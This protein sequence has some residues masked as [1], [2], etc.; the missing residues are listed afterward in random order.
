MW[1]PCRRFN[2]HWQLML[3]A[4]FSHCF[5][6]FTGCFTGFWILLNWC[7]PAITCAF[8]I[9]C[10]SKTCAA[11]VW[12]RK[13][14][15]RSFYVWKTYQSVLTADFSSL[16]CHTPVARKRKVLS[17]LQ[18]NCPPKVSLREGE[19]SEKE[20]SV[21]SFFLILFH[22]KAVSS[23]WKQLCSCWLPSLCI[24]QR[25]MTARCKGRTLFTRNHWNSLILALNKQAR[26][27]QHEI[28]WCVGDGGEQPRNNWCESL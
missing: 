28:A 15:E 3:A 10:L 18:E 26:K 25:E 4:K 8:N 1:V 23:Q 19:E 13:L 5:F 16:F 9:H 12:E 22:S 27:Q 20:I 14:N 6:V 17:F 2:S 7:M 21:S 24:R 11:E